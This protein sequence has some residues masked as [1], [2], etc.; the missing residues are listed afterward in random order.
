MKEQNKAVCLVSV[1]MP[2]YNAE[3]YLSDAVESVINQ[4]FSGWE[5]LIID[6]C[7]ADHTAVIASEY[8]EKDP[9]IRV[10]RNERNCGA[11]ET[12]HRGVQ[13]AAGNWIAFLD[14]DD[15]W[16]PEKLRLQLELAERT[17]AKLVFTASSF[18]HEDGTPY[19]YIFPVPNTVNY[20]Q[21]CRQNVI[22]NSSA[23][24]DRALFR[25]YEIVG[26]GM[27]EDFA[28][29]LNIL[30]SGETAYGIN[31]PLLTY[32]LSAASKS[33]NKIRAAGMNWNTYRR[34]GMS[35]SEAIYYMG[36]YTVRG[37]KKYSNL[38]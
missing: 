35:W 34:V 9:R 5:L 20:K 12:R 6:D 8:A 26:N 30:R 15:I 25:R 23:M 24:V 33:G 37:I 32:R 27:H 13:A 21:L 1:I 28:C 16:A 11:S 19:D 14:S 2:A 17:G 36:W 7:S 29:W 31:R 38:K 3:R 4:T 22:S 10:L 18:I